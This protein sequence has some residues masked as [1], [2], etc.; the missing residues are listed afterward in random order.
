MKVIRGKGMMMERT[1]KRNE[2]RIYEK[3]IRRYRRKRDKRKGAM[4]NKN[5]K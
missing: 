5:R 4:M 3:S 1:D 2:K